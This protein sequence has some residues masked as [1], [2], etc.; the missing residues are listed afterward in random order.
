MLL[1]V[2][3]MCDTDDMGNAVDPYGDLARVTRMTRAARVTRATRVTGSISVVR[4]GI[5]LIISF[6]QAKDLSCCHNVLVWR[7]L[8]FIGSSVCILSKSFFNW[9]SKSDA[10]I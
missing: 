1:K 7:E 9:I 10:M 5:P 2:A 3:A 4:I 8:Y 6:S